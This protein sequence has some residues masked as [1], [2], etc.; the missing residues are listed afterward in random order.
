MFTREY[1][2]R[3]EDGCYRLEH[4]DLEDMFGRRQR[5]LLELFVESGLFV[6]HP[7]PVR[8]MTGDPLL[9][10]RRA[11]GPITLKTTW[12]CDHMRYRERV[13]TFQ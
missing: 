2:K 6:I 5:P 12:Y 8:V 4:F 11:P 7:I 13:F 1:Y 3:S 10:K 9:F